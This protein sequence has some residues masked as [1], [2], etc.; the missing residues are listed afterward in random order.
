MIYNHTLTVAV[1]TLAIGLI[2]NAVNAFTPR[3]LNGCTP[4][5]W[6]SQPKVAIIPQN[7]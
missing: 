4:N 1:C 6:A 7:S 2:S 5:T 3:T